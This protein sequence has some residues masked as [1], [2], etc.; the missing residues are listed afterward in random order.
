MWQQILAVVLGVMVL[1]FVFPSVRGAM[2]RSKQAEEKHW[3][4]VALIA[5]VLIAFVI[6]MISSVRH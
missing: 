5:I 3:G 1:F 6:L 4:S 2:E